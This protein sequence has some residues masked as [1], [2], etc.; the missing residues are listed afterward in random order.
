MQLSHASDDYVANFVE[1]S[2]RI[3]YANSLTA[4]KDRLQRGE[5]LP[6]FEAAGPRDHIYFNPSDVRAAIVTCGGLCP[7]LNDV[8]QGIVQAL[9]FLYG[10]KDVLGIRYGYKGLVERSQLVPI[11]LTP[12]VVEYLHTRGGTL[13]G[14]SRGPQSVSEQ[15]DFL[16][17]RGINVLFAIGGDGTQRGALD[18][19]K[20]IEQRGLNISI[21]GIP[22]TIDNDVMYTDRS[23]GFETAYSVARE[24]ILS[25]HAEAQGAY[26]G[27]A[28]VKLM[29]RHSGMLAATATSASGEVNFTLIPEVPFDLD[30]PG[31]FL[32]ALEKRVLKRH[33]A[34]VVVAEGA[35]QNMI[36]NDEHK[37]ETDASGNVK[38]ADI[39]VFL[40]HRVIQHFKQREIEANARYIDPSYMVRSLPTIPS[41]RMFCLRLAHNA[42]HAAMSGRTGA[43]VGHWNSAFTHLPIEAAVSK[44]KVLDPESDL[45]LSVLQ[46]TGQPNRMINS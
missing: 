43:L 37:Q 4:V 14:S 24:V 36:D 9:Y 25:A 46:E 40:H 7:G 16:V 30:P 42:V 41:D 28:I 29:G 26:N 5:E 8:I 13:L 44:R 2:E 18:L 20:E 12:E 32:S 19:V 34:V 31:G 38:L 17:K 11:Q 6:S 10:V 15:V 3:I 22:K 33:H 39:G 45:W 1:D 35:G 27:I 21:I 23:F